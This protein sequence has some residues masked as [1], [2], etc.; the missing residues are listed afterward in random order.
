[1][2]VVNRVLM[3]KALRGPSGAS[4][5]TPGGLS[6]MPHSV[7]RVEILKCSYADL[8]ILAVAPSLGNVN[9]I[10]ALVDG[11]LGMTELAK[12]YFD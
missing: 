1:M 5:T 4:W 6:T 8:V 7:R 10:N 12:I 2:V 9:A 3:F 11:N